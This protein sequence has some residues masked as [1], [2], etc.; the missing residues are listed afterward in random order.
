MKVEKRG[1][2][3]KYNTPLTQINVRVANEED[4]TKVRNLEKKLLKQHLK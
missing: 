2:K 3:V 4:K 1:R